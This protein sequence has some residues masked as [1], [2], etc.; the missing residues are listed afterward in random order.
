DDLR[1]DL[2]FLALP[3]PS[4]E[5]LEKGEAH[6][7]SPGRDLDGDGLVL[8]MLEERQ[9]GPWT[10]SRDARFLVA[11]RPGDGP[12]Y[13]RWIEGAPGVE[14]TE[15]GD[16]EAGLP[17]MHWRTT[18]P[19]RSFEISEPVRGLVEYVMQSDCAMV[20]V[21]QGNHGGLTY[22]DPMGGQ[23]QSLY[24]HLGET[25]RAV[26]DRPGAPVRSTRFEPP[27]RAGGSLVDW[28]LALPRVWAM[29][30]SPWGM[31]PLHPPERAPGVRDPW[32]FRPPI[33]VED[34]PWAHWLDEKR[35]GEGFAPWR[36]VTSI[37]GTVCLVGGWKPRTFWNPP[38]LE[39]ESQVRGV[40]AFVLP[41][42]ERLSALELCDVSVARDGE[43]CRV[44][45]RLRALGSF[46]LTP[47][48]G[49]EK[50]VRD[51][52]VPWLQA[53]VPSHIHRIVGPEVRAFAPIPPGTLGPAV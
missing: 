24:E 50:N 38:E 46:P 51:G 13:D 26:A 10:P 11:A 14:P 52:A 4:V 44:R 20:L 25:F 31:P 18:D 6:R 33:D 9:D 35:G 34:R 47:G 43:L 7:G 21:F 15:V 17:A 8:E 48:V 2:T 1:S 28:C 23:A 16:L 30:I 49:S 22:P 39:L 42:V 53:N 12:R 27:G 37:D 41:L 29:E 19:D 3:F 36:P 40:V 45:A 32:E 5:L